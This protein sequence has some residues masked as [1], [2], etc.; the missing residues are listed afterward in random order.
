MI[1][2]EKIAKKIK[3][4]RQHVDD[5]KTLSGYAHIGSLRGP[6]IHDLMYKQLKKDKQDAIYTYVFNDF[7]PIDGLSQDLQKDFSK[8][9]GYP[10]KLAPSPDKKYDSFADYF[11]QDFQ[12]ILNQ[13]G[14][15]AKYLSSWQMYHQGKFDQVIKEAL[16]NA[17][18]IQDIYQKVSGSKKKEANWYPFQ[19]ICPKCHKVGTTRV[20]AWDGKQVSFICEEK[21]V[22]WAKGCGFKGKVSPFK[23]TGKLPWKVDWPAHWKVLGVTF[24]GAG[25]DHASKGGSYDIA[26]ALCEEVFNY[27]KPYY[28]PYEHFLMGGR[29][30]SSSKGIGFRAR[31][32][33]SI[34]PAE[35]VRF[36][37]IRTIPKKAI[38]F[39][40]E[41]LTIPNLFD[42]FDRCAQS[43]WQKTNQD[44]AKVFELSQVNSWYQQEV[45]LPRFK[46]IANYLQL[47]SVD[48]EEQ[49]AK[50]KKGK[51]NPQELAIL[52]KRIKYAQIWLDRFAQESAKFT[53]VKNL[54]EKA[55]QLSEKQKDY[56][57]QTVFLIEKEKDPEE[58]QKGLYQLAKKINLSPK[59][60]FAAIYLCLI[61]KPFGPRASWLIASLERKLVIE[62]FKNI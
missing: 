19:P 54:P 31:D 10:L 5:M 14:V 34:I 6:L 46:D 20:Y 35:L 3:G 9:M 22:T 50:V 16:D 36:L 21:M 51:L 45:F 26:F 17:S 27:P 8:Y 12:K 58:L 38:E 24:E 15:E 62:R 7:D 49:F 33:T 47:P 42:E 25:K 23:G 39:N 37:M 43:F 59:Q 32:I 60:A 61:N 40:P 4:R 1:W 11:A 18:K 2:A 29:K 44:L 28:F 57:R 56:L 41:G 52:K 55:K 30:M 13:L 53:F 48:L